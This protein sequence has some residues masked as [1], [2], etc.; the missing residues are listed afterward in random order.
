MPVP[1]NNYSAPYQDQ[2]QHW[3]IETGLCHGDSESIVREK[4]M[5]E[6]TIVIHKL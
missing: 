2:E 1:L 6:K 4:K 3:H 5:R